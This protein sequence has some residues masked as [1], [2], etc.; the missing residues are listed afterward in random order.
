[1]T[2]AD[3]CAQVRELAAELALGV[4]DG[5]ERALVLEHVASCP[6]CRHELERMSGVADELL[7]LAPE[8]EPPLGFELGVLRR[9]EPPTTARRRPWQRLALVAAI[10]VTAALTAG[11]MLIGFRD[12]RQLADRYRSALAQAHGYYFGA[13][14]LRDGSGRRAGSAF[15]YGGA[16]SWITITVEPAFRGTIAEAELVARDG[17]RIPLDSFRLDD[18]VWGGALP[19][20]LRD[21]AALHLVDR[22]GRSVLIADVPR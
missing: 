22:D 13:A 5:E 7:A 4:A 19:V 10:L 20:A 3:R 1:M 11:G 8:E 15:V 17:G 6:E 12:D 2:E 16:P 18:G 21:V 14:E 9:I